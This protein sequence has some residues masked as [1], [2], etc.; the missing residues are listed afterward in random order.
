MNKNIENLIK[1]C[2]C[3]A[4]NN[5]LIYG[6]NMEIVKIICLNCKNKIEERN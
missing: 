2:K 1:Q 6:K 4:E 5:I 3:G